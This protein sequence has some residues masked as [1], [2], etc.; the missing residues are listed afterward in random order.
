MILSM[1]LKLIVNYVIPIF[2]ITMLLIFIQM[3]YLYSIIR[4]YKKYED[5]NYLEKTEKNIKKFHFLQKIENYLMYVCNVIFCLTSI[6]SFFV[7]GLKAGLF[8]FFINLIITA[9]L[10][11]FKTKIIPDYFSDLD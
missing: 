11:F 7:I 1:F 2:I 10:I 5:K 6:I 4:N 3:L 8:M 9:M